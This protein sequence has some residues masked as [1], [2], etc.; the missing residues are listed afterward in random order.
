MLTR[1]KITC[2]LILTSL[3]SVTHSYG[4]TNEI[5]D[6]GIES[7]YLHTDRSCYLTGDSI[8]F[9]AYISDNVNNSPHP[10]N[11]TLFIALLD[12]DG[13]EVASGIF[14]LKGSQAEGKIELPDL[15]AEGNYIL[16]ASTRRTDNPVPERMFSGIIEIR[17][18]MKSDFSTDLSLADTLYEPGRLL[19]AYIRFYGKDKKPV[20]VNFTYQ[21]TGISSELVSGKSKAGNEGMATIKLQLPEFDNKETLKLL[22]TTT[23]KGKKNITGVVIPTKYNYPDTKTGHGSNQSTYEFKYL[24]IR[25]TTDKLLYDQEDQVRLDIYATD[26]KGTPVMANLSVS[27]SNVI[28]RQLPFKSDNLVTYPNLNNPQSAFTP[29]CCKE[30]SKIKVIASETEKGRLADDSGLKSLFN[31]RIREF[32]A[33]CLLQVTRSPGNQFNVQ[34]KN[35]LKKLQRIRKS[36]NQKNQ[37]G[38][39]SDRKIFD[40][41]MEI[42]PYHLENG[43]IVF[44]GSS[45][46]SINNLDGALIIVDG[47]RMGTDADILNS[48]PVPDIARI[49]ASTNISDIQR[50]SAMNSV[51]IIEIF[52]KKNNAYIIAEEAAGKSKSSTLFW[53][54]DIIT[55]SSGNASVTFFNNNKSADVIISVDGIAANG[56]FGSSSVHYS[57]K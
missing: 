41:L 7:V 30:V 39:S 21:L 26:D 16:I 3:F 13:L 47:I 23:Y 43:K 38:Y 36:V 42:K 46:N 45:L 29:S 15:L 37:Y 56:L 8:L 2:Y 51:G 52:M 22:V 34:E 10:V 24:K 48:I 27:A 18:Y 4:Q 17:K 50:Y 55:D 53:G 11:D 32:F 5:K 35:N 28:P 12:Q 54:P 40:I 1:I 49:T 44:G 33:E 19:S 31:L 25:L 57:V 14:P 9:K 6:P 20:P